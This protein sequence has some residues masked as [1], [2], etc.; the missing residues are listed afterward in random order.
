[1]WPKDGNTNPEIVYEG[2]DWVEKFFLDKSLDF[3][4]ILINNKEI[5]SCDENIAKS[6]NDSYLNIAKNLNLK[7]EKNLL[8]QNVELI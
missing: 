3:D 5:I 7:A 8:S 2:K 4:V 1:M 6:L